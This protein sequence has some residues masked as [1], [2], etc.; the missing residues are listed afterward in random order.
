MQCEL[1]VVIPDFSFVVATLVGS[2]GTISESANITVAVPWN[3]LFEGL[4]S[5]ILSKLCKHNYVH[6]GP[7]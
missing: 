7:H 1:E 5:R 6:Y 3:P 2:A 4:P